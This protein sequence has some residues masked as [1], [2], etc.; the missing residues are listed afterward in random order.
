MRQEQERVVSSAEEAQDNR[1]ALCKEKSDNSGSK[2]GE[3]F[4]FA[5]F[6]SPNYT[7]IPDEFFDLLAPRLSEAELRVLLYIMRRTFGFKKQADAISLSQLTGGIRKRNGEVQDNGTG[8]SK[9]AALK[10]VAG[11]QEK[12][13]IVVEKR[14]GEDG[15]NEVNVYRLRYADEQ[16]TNIPARPVS[17][18][19]TYSTVEYLPNEK[20]NVPPPDLRS[21][22]LPPLT[23]AA[24]QGR[25]QVGEVSTGVNQFNQPAT[26]NHNQEGVNQINYPGK[27]NL[28]PEHSVYKSS[29]ANL[30][31]PA[32]DLNQS[33][34]GLP[35]TVQQIYRGSKAARS[36]VVKQLNPQYG[37]LQKNSYQE[38]NDNIL[39][40][41]TQNGNL[42]IKSREDVVVDIT[43]KEGLEREKRGEIEQRLLNYGLS[44]KSVRELVANWP[45]EYIS[46][47]IRLAEELCRQQPQAVRNMAGFIRQAIHENYQPARPVPANRPVPSRYRKVAGP[48]VRTISRSKSNTYLSREPGREA[49]R[50]GRSVQSDGESDWSYAETEAEKIL[51]SSRAQVGKA[52]YNAPN[53]INCW[54][55]VCDAL[56]RRFRRE[57]LVQKLTGSDLRLD[58]THGKAYLKL[59]QPWLLGSLL[60]DERALLQLV[61]SQEVG[62]GYILEIGT[63]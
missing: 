36:E 10:G 24:G 27:L 2:R 61:I 1:I 5:G 62:P 63:A 59:G 12:G 34:A 40:R 6:K 3:G 45:L 38:T 54:E 37:S 60:S 7:P 28:P 49:R 48:G 50:S 19:N 15:R 23:L 25:R 57:D 47:K 35:G 30:P 39:P 9:P 26:E 4:Y 56:S 11:L 51:V 29:K 32:Y 17:Q 14:M 33:K 20:G 16:I 18:T 52:D 53:G 43:E 55:R 21:D 8:L 22:T 46:Q 13:I 42:A 41:L 58:A 44:H 31:L